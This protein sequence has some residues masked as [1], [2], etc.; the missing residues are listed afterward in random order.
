MIQNMKPNR[1]FNI[2][3]NDIESNSVTELQNVKLQSLIKWLKNAEYKISNNINEGTMVL[4]KHHNSRNT[5]T[6]TK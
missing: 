4:G 6:E 5:K 1:K 3:I 2:K